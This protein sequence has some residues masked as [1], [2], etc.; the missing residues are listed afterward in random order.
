MN[1]NS[2]NILVPFNQRWLYLGYEVE[3]KCQSV[4][5][6]LCDLLSNSIYV[7]RV[8]TVHE[9]FINQC[10]IIFNRYTLFFLNEIYNLKNSD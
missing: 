7:H 1:L 3:D 4:R 5:I 9:L 10:S 2:S 8:R 6:N